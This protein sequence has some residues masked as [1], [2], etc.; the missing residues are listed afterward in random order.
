MEEN[1]T[2]QKSILGNWWLPIR[3]WFYPAWFIYEISICFYDYGLSVYSYFM[4]YHNSIGAFGAQALSIF[5]GV[6]TFVI[7]T[8][9]LTV[10]ACMLLFKF[11][12]TKNISDN[13]V[14]ERIKN[15][16]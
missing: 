10:P 1:K 8:F 3:K 11:F 12:N 2:Q 6:A 4:E 7:C 5:C 16:L 15:Y 13:P 14:E 9:Y